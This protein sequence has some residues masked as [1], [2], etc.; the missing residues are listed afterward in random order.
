MTPI[1]VPG[2]SPVPGPPASETAPPHDQ[3]PGLRADFPCFRI[4]RAQTCDR[5]RYEAR[6]LHLEISPHT[7]VTDDIGELGAALEPARF[8][9]CP[10][11]HPPGQAPPARPPQAA[12]S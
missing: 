8:L 5:A 9:A 2:P 10:L 1:P 11:P 7:I 12:A 6:S 3:L 4:W